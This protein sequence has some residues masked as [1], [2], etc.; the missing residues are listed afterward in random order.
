MRQT[1]ILQIE[2][3]NLKEFLPFQVHDFF[4]MRKK[5]HDTKVIPKTA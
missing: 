4:D 2:L 5:T 3:F 1:S